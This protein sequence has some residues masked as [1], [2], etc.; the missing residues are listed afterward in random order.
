[1]LRSILAP[2]YVLLSLG[3]NYLV[4]MGI[5]EFL[6][7]KLLGFPGLSWTVSFFIFLIVVALGVDYS[8]F[9]M[10]RFKEEYRP[11]GVVPAM[12][13]AMK[14]TGGVII[15]A[16]VIMGGTF[17]AMGFSGVGTLVQIGVGTLIGL[18]LYA[19]VFMGLVVPSFSFLLGEANWWPFRRKD[20]TG[21]RSNMAA[22]ES[23]D[24]ATDP[25]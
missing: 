3:V 10:A 23:G 12:T 19:V 18:L 8:I 5:M 6:F 16:A 11:G 21:R 15:S 9:L 4:T 7:V 17:G 2:L 25:A 22:Q 13:K 20:E 24:P 14:T 1:F